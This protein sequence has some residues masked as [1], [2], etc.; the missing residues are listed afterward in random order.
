MLLII[1]SFFFYFFRS[2]TLKDEREYIQSCW[3]RL[4]KEQRQNI[5]ADIIKDDEGVKDRLNNL[6]N[7]EELS[8]ASLMETSN[9]NSELIK[10]LYFTR[11]EFE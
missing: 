8:S 10:I 6:K 4:V 1:I 5:P 9:Y 3:Q 2:Y 7:S 11:R